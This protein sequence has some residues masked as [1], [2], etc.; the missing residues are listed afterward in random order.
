MMLVY[1]TVGI[2]KTLYAMNV[3]MQDEGL[4]EAG[5]KQLHLDKTNI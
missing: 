1:L 2:K 4:F 3:Q 5:L